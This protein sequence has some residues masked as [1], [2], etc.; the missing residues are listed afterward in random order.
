MAEQTQRP[1]KV[2]RLSG[3]EARSFLQGLV[4]NDIER[5]KDG[6][7]YAALLTPQGK[8]LS[9]FFLV[10]DGAEAVLMDLPAAHAEAVAQRLRLYKLRAKVTIE[11]TELGVERGLGP[12]PEGA[13]ADPRHPAL[14]WRRYGPDLAETPRVAAMIEA[15]RI[16]Q[17]VPEADLELIPNDSYILEA[18]FDRLNGVDFRKGCYVGQE[19]VARMKHKTELRK[20][21]RPVSVSEPV[22]VGTPVLSAGKTAGTLYSQAEG[23]GLAFLRF[24]RI[25]P[26]MTA[27]PARVEL[28]AGD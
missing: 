13:F 11:T 7:V 22:P 2:L 10:P 20:G 5:L 21:L 16:A 4:T 24:D 15:A 23:L 17:A 28:A 12:V 1:R 14:G 19:I 9:D 25:G 8:Y 26:E 3:A 18:G 6:A 27:G